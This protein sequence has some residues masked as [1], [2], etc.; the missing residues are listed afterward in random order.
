[1][2]RPERQTL[3]VVFSSPHSGNAYPASF[4]AAAQLDPLTLRRSEDCF[5]DEI[6]ASAP[7]HGAPLLK[8]AVMRNVQELQHGLAKTRWLVLALPVAATPAHHGQ[9]HPYRGLSV[10]AP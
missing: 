9:G 4:I 3:P 7:A 2:I 8:V 5:V 6:V 10:A 1:M